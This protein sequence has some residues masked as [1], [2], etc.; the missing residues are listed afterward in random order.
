MNLIDL[1]GLQGTRRPGLPDWFPTPPPGTPELPPSYPA[2]NPPDVP[3]DPSGFWTCL[4]ACMGRNGLGG[5]NCPGNSQGYCMWFCS[6]LIPPGGPT[7]PQPSPDKCFP[8]DCPPWG[9]FPAPD[10]GEPWLV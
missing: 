8:V 6:P 2:P 1:K 4:K 9:D 5:Q 10:P 3:T 7:Y